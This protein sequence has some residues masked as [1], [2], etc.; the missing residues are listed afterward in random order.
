MNYTI[1]ALKLV[2]ISFLLIMELGDPI[3]ANGQADTAGV[4]IQRSHKVKIPV[5]NGRG[6]PAGPPLQLQSQQPW[7][8]AGSVRL[9]LLL[10]T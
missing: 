10:Q 5:G 6:E 3:S 7:L 2:T 9:S 4:E 1:F 8:H